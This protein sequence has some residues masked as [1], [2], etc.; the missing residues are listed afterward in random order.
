MV[1]LLGFGEVSNTFGLR[2]RETKLRKWHS[3]NFVRVDMVVRAGQ[4]E[5]PFPKRRTE[6]HEHRKQVN[7]L[8]LQAVV[9]RV[10]TIVSRVDDGR[11]D[12]PP[13]DSADL[14][15]PAWFHVTQQ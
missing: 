5:T 2:S 13:V 10:G 4:S 6:K 14:H 8:R 9:D 12:T 1:K 3:V 11:D 7:L 15:D